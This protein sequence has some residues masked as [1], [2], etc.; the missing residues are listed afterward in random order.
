MIFISCGS[1]ILGNSKYI[2]IAGEIINICLYIV[3]HIIHGLSIL[4]NKIN[5]FFD[6]HRGR[7]WLGGRAKII[8]SSFR[9]TLYETVVL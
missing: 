4:R 3:L 6:E 7:G 9:L 1:L 5:N 2:Y 8:Q